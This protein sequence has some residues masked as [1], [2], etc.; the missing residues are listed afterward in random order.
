VLKAS[1]IGTEYL[2]FK[3]GQNEYGWKALDL[4]SNNNIKWSVEKCYYFALDESCKVTKYNC[5]G[6]YYAISSIA[7][8][9]GGACSS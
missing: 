7:P 5:P 4:A 1:N 3:D 9:I 8:E 6:P 2:A